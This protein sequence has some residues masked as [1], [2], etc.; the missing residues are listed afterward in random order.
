MAYAHESMY[1][2][3]GGYLPGP[4]IWQ[5][6]AHWI[7]QDKATTV[8]NTLA[9]ISLEDVFTALCDIGWGGPT[10]TY[11][12]AP[13]T[14]LGWVKLAILKTD[15]EYKL[16]P[17]LLEKTPVAGNSGS[18]LSWNQTAMCVSLRTGQSLGYANHGRFYLPTPGYARPANATGITAVQATDLAKTVARSF[19]TITTELST[20]GQEMQLA[21]L[22]KHGVSKPVTLFSVG[23]VPDTQ[24]RRRNAVKE[25]PSTVNWAGAPSAYR[26]GPLLVS[27][28]A[29]EH[30]ESA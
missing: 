2:T 20:V 19:S 21:I 14:T 28:H 16:E 23:R 6:G 3:F 26:G 5:C 13:H 8:D 27:A 11:Q 10:G 18:G 15:G 30:D 17:K 25:D 1:L 7:R 4:E 22:S 12:C 29:D 24:R 9:S